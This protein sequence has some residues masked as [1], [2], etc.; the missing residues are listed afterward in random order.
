MISTFNGFS[1]II[2][3]N[4]TVLYF[5]RQDYGF[6]MIYTLPERSEQFSQYFDSTDPYDSLSYI[7][8]NGKKYDCDNMEKNYEKIQMF[9]T[10]ESNLRAIEALP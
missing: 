2:H 10:Q 1:R 4:I 5:T 9:I 6:K 8:I 7:K 3:S